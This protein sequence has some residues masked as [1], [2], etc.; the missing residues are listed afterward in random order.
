[1]HHGI[2]ANINTLLRARTTGGFGQ[3]LDN[4]VHGYTLSE[5]PMFVV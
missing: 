1:M 2:S 5:R 4:R 3:Q